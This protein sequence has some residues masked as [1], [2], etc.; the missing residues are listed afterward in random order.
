[1]CY[2]G[3]QKWNGA[4]PNF[5]VRAIV[6]SIDAVGLNNFIMVHLP[7]NIKLMIMA[8]ISN[9]E[10]VDWVRTYL[11]DASLAHGLYCFIIMGIIASIFI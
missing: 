3:T 7:E 11:V 5:M 4:I 6:M 1:M 10:A 9:I 8:I 2:F